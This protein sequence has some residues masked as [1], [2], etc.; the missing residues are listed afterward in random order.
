[1]SFRADLSSIYRNESLSLIAKTP[2]VSIVS[3][4]GK[5]TTGFAT[6]YMPF[7]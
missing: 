7:M 4:L 3:T 6:N 2:T 5:T 1:M